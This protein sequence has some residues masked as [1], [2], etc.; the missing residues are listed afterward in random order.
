LFLVTAPRMILDALT[1]DPMLA[2]EMIFRATDAVWARVGSTVQSFIRRCHTPGTVDR[3]LR[4]M[5]ASGRSEFLDQVWPLITHE[6]NQVSHS[7]LRAAT[8]FR[9]SLLGSDLAK[10]IAPL[11]P[12]T[13][14]K[15]LHEIASNSA[16][17]G[18]DLAA[19]VAKDDPDHDPEVKAMVVDALAFRRADRHVAELLRGADEKTFDLVTGSGLIDDV[20]DE[21]LRAG[22]D[23]ARKRRRKEGISTYERL[24]AMVYARDGEDHGGELTTI[25]AEML[26]GNKQGAEVHLVYEARNRYPRAIADGLL[27]RLRVG[28]ELFFGADDLLASAGFSLEDNVLLEIALSMTPRHDDRAEAAASVLGPQAMGGMIDAL[29]EAMRRVRDAS[30]GYDQAAGDRCHDL[31]SRI[32]H[33]PGA[34]LLAAIRARSS[35]QSQLWPA[36]RRPP[37]SFLYPSD[38]WTKTF[39]NGARS[40]NGPLL[41]AIAAAPRPTRRVRLGRCNT[42]GLFRLSVAPRRLR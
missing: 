40:G 34:S 41:N 30:G 17:D 39:V 2:A 25:I 23:A 22:L 13:R 37:A 4:F 31:L 1:I 16:M 18:L 6:N 12:N 42:R 8:R 5:I 27:Q 7:A 10:W 20:T 3:A 19:D 11:S 21:H 33:T 35:P 9:P 36:V 29:F 14:K 38:C 15:V 24:R 28:R 32:A 26:I